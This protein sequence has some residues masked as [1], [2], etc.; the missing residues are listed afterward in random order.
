MLPT[1]SALPVGLAGQQQG[2]GADPDKPPKKAHSW[3]LAAVQHQGPGAPCSASHHL[4]EPASDP[5]HL[6]ALLGSPSQ[7]TRK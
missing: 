2:G 6:P 4:G 7:K 3:P 1:P 5:L